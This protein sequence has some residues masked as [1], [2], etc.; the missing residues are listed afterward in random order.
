MGCIGSKSQF[1]FEPAMAW[2][3]FLLAFVGLLTE[4]LL[5]NAGFLW[6]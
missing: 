1:V 3:G 2:R 5:A 4:Y 6:L